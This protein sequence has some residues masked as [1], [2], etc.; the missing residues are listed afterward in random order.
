[1]LREERQ[2]DS[3]TRNPI[4]GAKSAES[5][6]IDPISNKVRDG[7]PKEASMSAAVVR[8]LQKA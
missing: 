3:F 8:E 1:M 2:D 5:F 4:L 6:A 7:R